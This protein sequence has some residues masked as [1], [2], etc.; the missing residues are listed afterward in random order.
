VNERGLA[1][2]SW[3]GCRI[4]SPGWDDPESRVL[5]F[6]LGGFPSRSS[7]SSDTDIHVM[8]NMD[9]ND[10]DFDV[11]A[12]DGR[13]WHRVIDTGARPPDDIFSKGHEPLFEGETCR[14][15]NRSIVVL[16]SKP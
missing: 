1:D 4:F 9:W 7:R 10:L 15:K 11:P 13:R 2:V 12:V 16:I 3:H 6:T 14:V 5:A 8:M